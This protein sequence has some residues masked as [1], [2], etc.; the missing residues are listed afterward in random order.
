[1]LVTATALRDGKIRE[2]AA[3][4]GY[5]R[6]TARF[7]FVDRLKSHLRC[8]D[9]ASLPWEE[10]V[11]GPLEPGDGREEVGL[12]HDLRDA[13]ERLPEKPRQVVAAVHIEGKTYDEAARDTG[14]PLGSLKRYLREGL[15]QLRGELGALIGES[16][17]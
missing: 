14:I 6:S 17:Q 11:E 10:V 13:L 3:V 2:R 7:K 4:V 12:S 1:V 9:G 15:A 8:G 5:L 16:P